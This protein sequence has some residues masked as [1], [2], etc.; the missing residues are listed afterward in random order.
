MHDFAGC[1]AKTISSHERYWKFMTQLTYPQ[2]A[3][4]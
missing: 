4:N 1:R 3:E 2:P